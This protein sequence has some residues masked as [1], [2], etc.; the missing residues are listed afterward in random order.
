MILS[1][2]CP[3]SF[4]PHLKSTNIL[5]SALWVESTAKH[6]WWSLYSCGNNPLEHV[7]RFQ[8][9]VHHVINKHYCPGCI[10]F[11][12]CAHD[13]ILNTETRR[14]K[15][16]KPGS[17]AHVDFRKIILHCNPKKR[18]ASNVRCSSYYVVRGKY[19]LSVSILQYFP[20]SH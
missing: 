8:S 19:C 4:V 12:Q 9:I 10:N 18:F 14:M 5:I 11:N 16:M 20:F 3:G 13:P 15:W 2:S 17:T 1:G 6:F 7:E